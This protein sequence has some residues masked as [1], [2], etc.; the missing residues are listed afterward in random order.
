MRWRT[1][2]GK[3]VEIRSTR[4]VSFVHRAVAAIRYE[5]E[6]ID[7]PV[8]IVVQSSLVANEPVPERTDDPR[9]GGRA[10]RAA[11]RRVPRH[12]GLEVALG[13]RARASGLLIAAGL[14]HVVEGRRAR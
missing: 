3:A 11:R 9:R 1:P 8:R 12:R 14:D 4:L 2:T 5:V 7:A 10:A 13:H 6:A